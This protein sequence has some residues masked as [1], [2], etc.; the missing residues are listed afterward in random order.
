MKKLQ[1]GGRR[2]NQTGRPP[3]PAEQKMRRRSI[4]MLPADW[5]KAEAMAHQAKVSVD[6]IMR[7]LIRAAG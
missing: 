2:K 5:E 6:E 7:R 1:H 3:L 4:G